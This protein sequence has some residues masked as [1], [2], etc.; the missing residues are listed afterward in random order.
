MQIDIDRAA[1]T[2]R[3]TLGDAQI[4]AA[5]IGRSTQYPTDTAADWWSV[6]TDEWHREC[7]SGAVPWYC[8]GGDALA[9]R[10][11]VRHCMRLAVA[12]T[13]DPA[14]AMGEAGPVGGAS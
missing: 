7:R 13:D 8:G 6:T 11:Q 5:Y 12:E 1:A 3:V 9:D 2:I 4:T 10:L 14:A